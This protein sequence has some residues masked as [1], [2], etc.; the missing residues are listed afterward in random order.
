VPPVALSDDE[1]PTGRPYLVFDDK[2]GTLHGVVVRLVRGLPT[3]SKDTRV[4]LVDVNTGQEVTLPEAP[5]GFS[6]VSGGQCDGRSGVSW[7]AARRSD[8]NCHLLIL[9]GWRAGVGQ[10][11]TLS[12]APSDRSTP[13][14]AWAG[15]RRAAWRFV[16][17][18]ASGSRLASMD[19]SPVLKKGRTT[20]NTRGRIGSISGRC[21]P[22]AGLMGSVRCWADAAPW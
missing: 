11:E 21:A 2:G 17:S 22:L 3:V 19:A 5:D 8:K 16:P 1:L 4:M 7:W 20:R 12:P 13:A 14:P 6:R 9:E 10:R 15:A 18:S